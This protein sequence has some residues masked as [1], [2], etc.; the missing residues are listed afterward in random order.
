MRDARETTAELFGTGEVLTMMATTTV[1]FPL[2]I[3]IE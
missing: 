1:N 3:S 2:T